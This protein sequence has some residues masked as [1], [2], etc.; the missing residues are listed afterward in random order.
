MQSSSSRFKRV[1]L[2]CVALG[3]ISVSQQALAAGTAA[4]TDITNRATVNF[5]VGGVTQNPVESSPT[6]NSNSGVGNGADTTFKVDNKLDLTVTEVGAAAT[7]V[8]AGAVN[9]VTTFKLTNTGN[10]QQGY[11][12]APTQIGGTLFT[13]A[14]TFDVT[15]VRRFVSTAACSGVS[16]TPTYN[17]A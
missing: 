3:A 4:N 12:L 10:F 13:H 9:Q 5:Q 1:A 7:T 15:N 11:Q 2:A 8:S 6:G 17:S 16:P 14:D